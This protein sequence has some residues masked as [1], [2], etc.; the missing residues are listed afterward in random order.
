M[1][2][3][4]LAADT[5]C[6]LL[7]LVAGVLAALQSQRDLAIA[8]WLI[9]IGAALMA[10]RWVGWA[11]ATDTPMWARAVVGA[12]LGGLLFALL[13]ASIHWINDR[14]RGGDTPPHESIQ[15]PPPASVPTPATHPHIRLSLVVE[16]VTKDDVAFH[17]AAT[18]AGISAAEVVGYAYT[19]E[20][21]SMVE[22]G[23]LMPR[24]LYPG[25]S[26]NF[27]GQPGNRLIKL[28]RLDVYLRYVSELDGKQLC[29]ESN[30]RFVLPSGRLEGQSVSPLSFSEAPCNQGQGAWEQQVMAPVVE[31]L[32][33]E[34]GTMEFVLPERCP[35]GSPNETSLR[36]GQR[37][38]IFAPTALRALFGV[39]KD[40]G[41]YTSV[42]V[43]FVHANSGNHFVA[44]EWDNRRGF[45]LLQVDGVSKQKVGVFINR[46]AASH[47]L[48][49]RQSSQQERR[50]GLAMATQV[51]V[52]W[53]EY[54]QWAQRP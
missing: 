28:R 26:V 41:E 43:P 48:Q 12:L 8:K 7:F 51:S 36:Y 42:E 19:T 11:A 52:D 9:W 6:G 5:A 50:T 53:R 45:L 3:V 1:E 10:I 17:V 30:S 15:P 44:F 2:S 23:N 4:L 37:L 46:P 16:S 14:Q 13:P 33:K 54:W 20:A 25:D 38:F 29:T 40:D 32:G 18:N 22:P 49:R 39:V 34:H 35:D 31:Q 21:G 47:H 24:K 27:P